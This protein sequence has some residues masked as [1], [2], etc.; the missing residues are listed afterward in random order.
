MRLGFELTR[1]EFT[2]KVIER[3]YY[4]RKVCE[5]VSV[6]DFEKICEMVITISYAHSF[7]EFLQQ[8]RKDN[9]EIRS[10]HKL[11]LLVLSC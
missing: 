7:H 10:R 11:Y 1:S 2:E 8:I 6:S 3:I 9:I 5:T 4:A